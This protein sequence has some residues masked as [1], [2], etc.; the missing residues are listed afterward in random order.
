M[1]KPVGA[2]NNVYYGFTNKYSNRSIQNPDRDD[3]T[4]SSQS[5][6]DLL[7][8]QWTLVPY[9]VTSEALPVRVTGLQAIVEE[10]YV[11]LSWRITENV[12]GEKFIIQRSSDPS[13]FVPDS[14]GQVF[15]REAGAESYEFY[16][17]AP[18]PGLNYYR[19]KTIDRDRTFEYTRYVKQNYSL[20]QDLTI[21]PQ[22]AGSSANV[23][24]ISQSEGAN[25]KIEVFNLMGQKVHSIPF[26]TLKGNNQITVSTRHYPAGMYEFRLYTGNQ[27]LSRKL[28]VLSE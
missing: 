12:N 8:I 25:G 17:L 21:F 1:W 14:I 24:F 6:A 5:V 13:K 22:P 15:L 20:L 11:K 10:S 3:V 18:K 28:L 4:Q 16:D 19:L 7:Q 26:A 9:A 27:I 23:T 2:D